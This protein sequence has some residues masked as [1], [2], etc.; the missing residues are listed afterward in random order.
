MTGVNV[1]AS[2]M[3]KAMALRKKYKGFIQAIDNP[4]NAQD[5]QN[6]AKAAGIIADVVVDIDYQKIRSLFRSSSP[7][8]GAND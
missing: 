7:C 8:F 3:Q 2:K 1:T 6:A 4:Q 5:L